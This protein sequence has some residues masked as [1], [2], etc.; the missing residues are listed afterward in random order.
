[1]E[2]ENKTEAVAVVLRASSA[3][4]YAACPAS[5]HREHGLPY[6]DIAPEIRATGER[7][8]AYCA[9]KA[10][11]VDDPQIP[12]M[13]DDEVNTA[14]YL[15]GK[16][17]GIA[18]GH[19]GIKRWLA[20][21]EQLDGT[22]PLAAWRGK[23]DGVA[24]LNEGML[25]IPD[26]KGG[27]LDVPDADLNLQLRVY[28]VLAWYN[29]T[30][31]FCPR[32]PVACAIIS[33]MNKTPTIYDAAAI[34]DA[35]KE[36][37]QIEANVRAAR[38]AKGNPGESQCRYCKA[39]CSSRCPETCALVPAAA[40]ALPSVAQIGALPAA[41]VARSLPLV[42]MVKAACAALE[43]RAKALLADDPQAFGGAWVL[44]AGNTRREIT[45]TITSYTATAHL[46]DEKAFLRSCK[47]SRTALIDE[48]TM[49]N[50]EIA[51]NTGVKMTKKDSKSLSAAQIDAAL[52]ECLE[53]KTN[54]PSLKYVGETKQ[55]EGETK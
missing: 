15:W 18:A 1:M 19:G 44:E 34:A 42:A 41:D 3:A 7:I 14:S 22:G 54:A 28:A 43:A 5:Y 47:V 10:R 6:R 38:N 50:L 17:L 21:E 36:L 20:V 37:A 23:P 29:Q 55:I 32:D 30:D 52:G 33:R 26:Y 27:W 11:G 8:H 49:L 4:R 39:F 25:L 40:K 45:D 12:D 53:V 2:T 35:E 51:K 48:R 31:E 46:L 24:R 13:T 9:D 16:V